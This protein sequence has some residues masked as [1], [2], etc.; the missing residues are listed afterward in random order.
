MV[1]QNPE[2][3][4]PLPPPDARRTR[5]ATYTFYLRSSASICGSFLTPSF[6]PNYVQ[7][8]SGLS[9]LCVASAR[10]RDTPPWLGGFEIN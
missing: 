10:L 2:K 7:P 3:S 6:L 4:S 1:V 9:D 5:Q 8:P